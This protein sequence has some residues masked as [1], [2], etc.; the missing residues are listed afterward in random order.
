M[1]RRKGE[2]TSHMN[3]RDFPQLVELELPPGGFRSQSL[4]FEAFHRERGIPIRRGR[5]AG[6]EVE[7]THRRVTYGRPGPSEPRPLGTTAGHPASKPAARFPRGRRGHSRRKTCPG[8]VE[9]P[10]NIPWPAARPLASP[11]TSS[12]TRTIRSRWRGNRGPTYVRANSA[13]SSRV[14][15]VTSRARTELSSARRHDTA[16]KA[17]RLRLRWRGKSRTL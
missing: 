17:S 9:G 15:T 8:G 10:P 5:A 13:A 12:I 7:K 4:E 6:H 1:S 16:N 2:I 3:E 11:D 14:R